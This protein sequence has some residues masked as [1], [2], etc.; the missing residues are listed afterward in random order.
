MNGESI[1]IEELKK[2]WEG[3]PPGTMDNRPLQAI[4]EEVINEHL[5]LAKAKQLKI[6]PPESTLDM[7]LEKMNP[8]EFQE[9]SQELKKEMSKQW[10][11]G[12]VSSRICPL[13]HVTEEEIKGYYQHHKSEFN[14][15]AQVTA[16]Q[17]VVNSRKAARE[18]L[19]KLKRKGNFAEVAKQY[20]WG[21]EK[22]KGGLLPPIYKG[23]EPPGFQILFR[24]RKGQVSPIIKS[25]YG[26]HIFKIVDK[27]GP[28]VIPYKKAHNSIATLLQLNKQ[29]ACLKKWLIAARKRSHIEVYKNKLFF[30]EARHE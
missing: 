24:L 9:D 19:R 7:M 4:L 23:K 15:P 18:V 17:I 14:R 8:R 16:R 10:I 20:S 28:T 1:T 3:I 2:H 6:V 12:E 21:P 26:F 22:R 5:L 30:S 27:K 29:K 11:L 13:P 25:P